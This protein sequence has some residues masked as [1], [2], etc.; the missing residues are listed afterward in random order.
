MLARK[1]LV[2]GVVLVA[3]ACSADAPTT[4]VPFVPAVGT[5]AQADRQPASSSGGVLSVCKAA[6]AGVIAGQLFTSRISLSD[7]TRAVTTAAGSCTL[8]AVP[9]DGVPQKKGYFQS[10]PAEVERLL[11]RATTLQVDGARPSRADVLAILG[12]ASNV[13]ASSSLLLTLAQQLIAG[14]LNVL[15]GVQAPSAV[16]Q[17]IA[18][19]NAALRIT[20]GAQITIATTLS[21]SQMSALVNTLSALNEGKLKLP[22]A[23]SALTFAI[24]ETLGTFSEVA[25]IGCEPASDCSGGSTA[26]GSVTARVVGGATTVVTYT[27]QSKPVLRV[28]KAAGLGV[29]AGTVS[30]FEVRASFEP[31]KT[32]DVPAGECRETET[33]ED[34]SYDV[35]ETRVAGVAVADISCDPSTHCSEY[36]TFYRSVRPYVQRGITT[37]TFTN[38]TTFGKL[39]FCKVAGPGI[40]AGALFQL[41]A[42]NSFLEAAYDEPVDGDAR[43]AN[44]ECSESTLFEGER[45]EVSETPLVAGV[46][47]SD[48]TCEP[49][50]RCGSPELSLYGRIY[51]DIVAGSTTT[52]TFTSRSTLGTLKVCQIAGSGVTLGSSFQFLAGGIGLVPPNGERTS[53]TLSVPTGECREVVLYEGTYNVNE[54]PLPPGT[55]VDVINCLPSD[56]CTGKNESTGHVAATIVGGSTTQVTFINSMGINSRTTRVDRRGVQAP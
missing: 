8:L 20:L 23:P 45:Y 10:N 48:I 6:G 41:W 55:L 32:F 2:P 28:C 43:L 34:M 30:H 27:T 24:V 56:R 35:T 15:R 12:G 39:K 33:S 25:S 38:R 17:A 40:V 46:A 3:L 21:T 14:E 50:I 29:T 36:N 54:S 11:P 44:G 51:A 49:T 26:T 47:V 18:D 31:L 37:V 22:A 9:L 19:A 4:P 1:L 13:K 53:A 7:V 42:T 52:V 5:N 16:L